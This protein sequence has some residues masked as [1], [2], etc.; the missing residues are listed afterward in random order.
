[1][2]IPQKTMTR[3]PPNCSVLNISASLPPG[4]DRDCGTDF[5]LRSSFFA[6]GGPRRLAAA[7]R[8]ASGFS[9]QWRNQFSHPKS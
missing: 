5:V 4:R 1:M 7:A 2:T 3:N 6:P 8:P 9:L